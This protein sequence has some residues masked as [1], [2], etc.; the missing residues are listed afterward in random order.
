METVRLAHDVAHLIQR[1]AAESPHEEVCGL[2]AADAAGGMRCQPVANIARDKS[3]VFEMDPRAQIDALRAIRERSE[4]L[5]GIY[6]SHPSGAAEPSFADIEQHQYPDAL[7]FIVVLADGTST[8]RA[9]RIRHRRVSEI[10]IEVEPP[11]PAQH[12]Y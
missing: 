8:L 10:R 12:L 4:R 1:H 7:C 11:S 9:F 6:H 2:I 5:F 3:R